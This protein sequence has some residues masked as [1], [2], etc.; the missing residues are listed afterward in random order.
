MMEARDL[1][2]AHS[3]LGAR[4]RVR[5]RQKRGL[6][7]LLLLRYSSPDNQVSCPGIQGSI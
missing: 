5:S 2:K 3:K 6:L 7:L 1:P 4:A